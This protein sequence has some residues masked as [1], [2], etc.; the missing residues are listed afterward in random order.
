[1]RYNRLL[2][3]AVVMSVLAFSSTAL[4]EEDGR[5]IFQEYC[6]MCHGSGMPEVPQF[7]NRDHWEVPIAKG[8]EALYYSAIE[9]YNAMPPKGLCEQCSNAQIKAA[10][11]YMISGSR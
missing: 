8:K 6:V 10:V 1:M 5:S 7:G 11:D 4:A 9:G 3:I 2:M